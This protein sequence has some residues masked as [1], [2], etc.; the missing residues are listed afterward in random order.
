MAKTKSTILFL[1]IA[2]CSFFPGCY[3]ET[4][5]NWYKGNTH[6]HTVI[7]GHADTEPAQVTKW[8]HDRGYHFLILSEHNHFIDPDSVDM[9]EN[10][11]ED[12]ILIPGEEV[13]GHKAIHTT[14]MNIEG[15][16][17][18]GPDL[19]TKT[20]IIQS[21]VDST[22]SMK[23]TPILNHPNF[24]SGASAADVQPVRGLHMFELYNGHPLVYNWGV[25]GKHASTEE[26][27][28]SLLSSGMLIY[29]VSSDD[30]HT[31][32]EWGHD[33]SNPGRGWVMVRSRELTA[34]A[35][36]HAME[37]GDFYATSG[38]ILE[39]LKANPQRYLVKVD[40]AQTMKELSS[41]YVV[42]RHFEE[43]TEGYFI[44]FIGRDGRVLK[45]VAGIKANY[46]ARKDDGYI[47]GKVTFA[48]KTE[49][50]YEA[51]YA[52]TQPV[53]LKD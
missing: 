19:P 12:F 27:W 29:G 15:Y 41:P 5:L 49:K 31:F 11:R 37:D 21:H 4:G 44:E 13:T 33:H 22:R 25:E 10:A 16:V 35:I 30:A 46:K 17:E 32:Q 52:W 53:F 48:R 34:E 50:G 45:T 51:F 20:E 18:P 6:A 28:D 26:K 7:C 40:T 8:Y 47:R 38:I 1:V 2:S 3:P 14:A 42:G 39:E 9:P 43:A 36:T 24:V 23:G